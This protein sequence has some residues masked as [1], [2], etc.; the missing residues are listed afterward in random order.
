MATTSTLTRVVAIGDPGPTQQQITTA[1]S[2]QDEFQLV[3]ILG[4][5]ERLVREVRA[6]E[7]DIILVDSALEGQPTLDIIDDLALQFPKTSIVAV[8]PGEDP[9]KAQQVMLAGARAFLVQPFTQLNLLSTLRRVRDLDL[10]MRQAMPS[11]PA[12]TTEVSRPLRLLT[13]FSPK[14]GSGCS[15]MALN[16]AL[17]MYEETGQQVL[18]LEGKMFFGDLGVMLNMRT[19][20]TIADL[21]PHAASLDDALIRDVISEHASGLHVLLAPGNVQIAQGIRPDDLYNILV[22]VQ[23]LYNLIVVDAGNSLN[24]NTVTFLDAADRILLVSNPDLA[25]LHDVS[26]FIQ[27]SRTLAYPA[28]KVLVAVNRAGVPGGVKVG[29]I[30]TALHHPIFGQVPDDGPK[31]L[32]SIN[33]GV[34]LMV[35]YP[36]SP[37]SQAIR[38][39]GKS[40][41]EIKTA[42]PATETTEVDKDQREAL[43]RSSQLG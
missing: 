10:R 31:P 11:G 5:T 39:L 3:D 36:R 18:L 40:L 13:V 27:V 15:T 14:G 9:L 30:E 24:E 29:D 12:K 22:G 38:L 7:P 33:R 37:A 1:L 28:E 26:R 4:S 8:L 17:S 21:V 42:A 35:R 25:S 6:A 19:Q 41:V 32:L 2:A 16:L 34:P 23:R 20:N 43:L